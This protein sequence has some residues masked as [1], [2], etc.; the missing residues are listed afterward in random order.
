[1]QELEQKE[2]F[3]FKNY[4]SPLTT[5][6]A[7]TW[8][9]IIGLAVFCNG[10]FNSFVGD[11][12]G[13]IVDNIFVHSLSNI[14]SFFTGGTFYSGVSQNVYGIYYRPLYFTYFTIIYSLV[15]ANAFFFHFF[16]LL[17]HIT[18]T[19]LLF[20]LFKSFFKKQVAFF[21]SLVFL[22]HPINSEAVLYIADANDILFFFFG[23]TALLILQ[24]FHS[25]K[26]LFTAS[27]LFLF[28]L[29]S[30]ESGVLFLLIAIIYVYLF[31]KKKFPSVLS[32][33]TIVFIVYLLFRFHAI[34]YGSYPSSAPISHL[35]VGERLINIPSII[36]FY[37]ETFFL[38][39]NLASS[40]Q[41]TYTAISITHFFIPL[42]TD[43]VFAA[44]IIFIAIYLY[45]K[46][47][48]KSFFIFLFFA[49]WFFL[50]LLFYLQFFP[51]DQ[52]VAE[53]WFYFPI[54]GLLGT[55]GVIISKY[56]YYQSKLAI[57]VG[58]LIIILLSTRTIIR[59][60]DWRDELS[61]ASHDIKVSKEAYG[62]ENEIS[63]AYYQKGEYREAKIHAENAINIYPYQTDYLNLGA[64]DFRLGDYQNAKDAYVEAVRLG[65]SDQANDNLAFI[66][67]FYGNPKQSM[68]FIKN[69]A[70]RE[71]P[72]DGKLWLYLAALEYNF[73][74][75]Q[76][77][78]YDIQQAY[79]YDPETQ[80]IA[81]YNAIMNNQPVRIK[82]KA[83][84]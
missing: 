25:A 42:F 77:A 75:K 63:Y 70:L 55:I 43:L 34:G 53:R 5:S 48:N 17:L 32:V 47:T 23:I 61:I 31:D 18:S 38:P 52:T 50:G 20:F 19:I 44:I 54:V 81:V 3:S 39:V 35:S 1:M 49:L 66:G 37:L 21:L 29:F 51:L 68:N 45:K 58:V 36:L 69:T 16:Q 72:Y 6:K 27:L 57:I 62:L 33:N 46:S 41:W 26:A 7:V 56:R 83:K 30:K 78:V 73:G 4:F 76:N 59:T 10:L 12:L 14:F 11:D 40:Y 24:K 9:V 80:A 2:E 84:K 60:F 28:S 65:D 82:L 15:G 71:N 74:D 22:I 8:I 67:L 64:A 79:K 13:Q